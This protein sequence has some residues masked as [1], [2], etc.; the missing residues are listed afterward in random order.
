MAYVRVSPGKYRD[1]VTGKVI[2]SATDPN[3]TAAKTPA[4]GGTAKQ[5]QVKPGKPTPIKQSVP[6]NTKLKT[7][8]DVINTNLDLAGREGGQQNVLNNP[9]QNNPFYNQTTTIDPAT[10]QPTV[11]STLSGGEQRSVDDIQDAGHQAHN[12]LGSTLGTFD[13]FGAGG[14]QDQYGNPVQAGNNRFEQSVFNQLTSGLKEQQGQ[15]QEQ[16]SQRLAD[17]GISVGSDAYNNEMNRFQ[18]RYDDQ[19]NNARATAV[20]QSTQGSISAS[21]VLGNLNNSGYINPN[22]QGFNQGQY[23]PNQ[24]TTVFGAMTQR[25]GANTAQQLANRRNQPGG[26]GGGGGA[27]DNAFFSGPPPGYQG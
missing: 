10:G 26:G 21:N 19:F 5:P 16:L 14:A 3:K 8:A 18:K 15:E 27:S 22:M 2:N 7:A 9:N 11:T 12:A 25:M 4:S 23:D 20:Q 1:S 13:N 6:K 24:G 17:Q